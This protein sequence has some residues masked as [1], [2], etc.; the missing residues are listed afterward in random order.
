MQIRL[1]V[2]LESR[3][4]GQGSGN[5]R[6]S[7]CEVLVTAPAGTVLA[8]VTG[9]LASTAASAGGGEGAE[10]AQ[11]SV[12]VYAGTERLDPHRQIIGEPPLLDGAVISLHGPSAPT[13]VPA[14]G[15]AMARLHVTS[16][17]DAGGIHLLQGGNVR[18]GR[19]AESD[20]PLD[21]PDVSRTHCV[22][23]VTD[24]GA[25]TVTDL[26]STNGTW[27]DGVPVGGQPVL[28]RPGSTLTLGESAVRLEAAAPAGR[29]PTVPALPDGNGRLRL[30]PSSNTDQ[31]AP[32]PLRQPQQAA[33]HGHSE[34]P[35]AQTPFPRPAPSR[36]EDGTHG[37][38][39]AGVGRTATAEPG[40]ERPRARGLGAWGRLFGS[41]AE[42]P[43]APYTGPP[44]APQL[45]GGAR[46]A[47][48]ADAALPACRRDERLPDPAA[49]LL[50]ALGPGPRLWEREPGH[51]D[52]LTVRLGSAHTGAGRLGEPVT[53]GL[54]TE[55]A[56]G[57]AGPRPRLA[58]LARS[59]L[60]QLA[61]T[62]GPSTLEI[63][64]LATDGARSAAERSEEW[65]WLGRLPHLRPVHGQDCRLLTA[66]DHDQATA[67]TAEL[68]RRLDEERRVSGGGAVR[69]PGP[70]TVLVVDGDPGTPALRDT[71][72]RLTAEGPAAGVHVL[73]LAD[74]PP[75]TP[76]S[77][78]AET[79]QAAY[80]ASPAFRECGTLALLSGAVATAV[81]VVRRDPARPAA[82]A[83]TAGST[84]ATVDAV[85]PAWA[86]RFARA[87]A[88]LREPDGTAARTGTAARPVVTLPRSARLLDELGLA[89]ATPAALLARWSEPDSVEAGRARLVLGAGPRGPVEEELTATRSHALITGTAGTGKTEL[90][91][92]LAASLAA[93]ERPDRLRLVLLD[94]DGD[95]AHDGL[96]ACSELPH[97][98][99]H[100]AAGDPVRMREFAQALTSELKYRAEV[101][102][103][104]GTFEEHLR[105]GRGSR[106]P[107]VI[108]PR[109]S[110]EDG[111]ADA[112][113]RALFRSPVRSGVRSGAEGADD[114]ESEAS[115]GTLR[116]RPRAER[117]GPAA[118]R[119]EGPE[120][121]ERLPRLVLLVDD[122]DTLVEPALGNPGRPSAGSVVRALESV[123]RDGARLGMHVVAATGRPAG[124]AAA[125]MA[126]SELQ[127]ELTAAVPE[128]D[129]GEDAKLPG[130]GTLSSA[131]GSSTVF[132]SGRVTGRIPRTATRR[133]TV[134]PL[135]WLRAGD[136]PTRRPVRELGNGPTDLALL[137][138]ATV[139]AAQ[140]LGLELAADPAART[141]LRSR[142]GQEGALDS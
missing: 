28:F 141:P 90:L 51:P 12:A 89:R 32:P 124:A 22:I 5:T 84:V 69:Q 104:D 86:E 120:A 49:L 99:G 142:S 113:V 63:V 66:Y 140:S 138:S 73:A 105:S 122:L 119:G 115:R 85:S 103:P 137:A 10:S 78:L 45:P 33:A 106:P 52:A 129:L 62:H 40:D 3:G 34:V 56:L 20:V 76:A 125:R 135:D 70:Y 92:S 101:V 88:P 42:A 126:A 75:A 127:V 39:L 9:A 11:E 58:G 109:T 107:R 24:G 71:V 30:A 43:A 15:P 94:G 139:R 133:P 1:T 131:G 116:L 14:Y 26:Q 98:S 19:S 59:V 82:D 57:L 121:D 108:T 41:R 4:G 48:P 13:A 17:P 136:P 134:V 29:P 112:P 7:M 91:R 93:G 110:P 114:L 35:A 6:T 87:L 64:L 46:T 8:A 111:A 97:V 44:D 83:V 23:T 100:L 25:V 95:A 80:T 123:A 47:E 53:A 2:A 31:A 74:A 128:G 65:A 21:D 38:G 36:D 60:A 81:R 50:M 72:A 96:R 27:L 37:A 130:R 118:G 67:R 54:R 79:V 77:P 55:G 132:Q 16:G 102:G 18:L 117:G 61:A 68:T